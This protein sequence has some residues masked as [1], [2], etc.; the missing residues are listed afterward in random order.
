MVEPV[1]AT[2]VQL[3]KDGMM[4]ESVESTD[5]TINDQQEQP[6][7][8]HNELAVLK[9]LR[10]LLIYLSGAD[11]VAAKADEAVQQYFEDNGLVLESYQL[12][13][14]QSKQ[15]K[16]RKFDPQEQEQHMYLLRW[17][18]SG[19]IEGAI[20]KLSGGTP[21]VRQA[22]VDAFQD[23]LGKAKE[24]KEV[25]TAKQYAYL[26]QVWITNAVTNPNPSASAS[27]YRFLTKIEAIERDAM[28]ETIQ[29]KTKKANGDEA[30]LAAMLTIPEK[31]FQESTKVLSEAAKLKAWGEKQLDKVRKSE[32]PDFQHAKAVKGLEMYLSAFDRVKSEDSN[33]S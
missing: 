27:F 31:A 30:A 12:R 19:F 17:I 2:F 16:A 8:L 33:E 1:D 29:R 9:P 26:S 25:L 18:Q 32:T 11:M 5:Q 6:S 22:V 4:P 3:H 14:T 28:V 23:K 10:D 20:A 13:S 24:I 7:L 21:K 15:V